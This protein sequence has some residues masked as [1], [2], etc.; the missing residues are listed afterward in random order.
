M[1]IGL[2][3]VVTWLKGL[4]SDLMLKL[5]LRG[6]QGQQNSFDQQTMPFFILVHTYYNVDLKG[7]T[8]KMID[9][10][11]QFSRNLYNGWYGQD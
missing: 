4:L 10:L 3:D 7:K 6:H 9:P 8:I 1:K 2:L 11:Q 5:S